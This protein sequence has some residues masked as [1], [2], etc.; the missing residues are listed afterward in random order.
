MWIKLL[1][2]TGKWVAITVLFLLGVL[3]YIMKGLLSKS[4]C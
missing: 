1:K 4:N 3:Y 2:A